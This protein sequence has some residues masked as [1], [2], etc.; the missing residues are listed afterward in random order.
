MRRSGD[1]MFWTCPALLQGRGIHGY[2]TIHGQLSSHRLLHILELDRQLRRPLP[3]RQR[4]SGSEYHVAVR[5]C[6]FAQKP[7]H[8][9]LPNDRPHQFK[10]NGTYRTPW[11][12]LISGN[13][14]AQ[15]GAPFSQ[16]IPHPV[17]GDNEG[18][19][20]PR[21]TAIVPAIAASQPGFPNVVNSVGKNRTPITSNTDVGLYYPVKVGEGREL[22]LQADWFNV[23]NQQRAVMLD[24]TFLINSGITGVPPVSNPFYGSAVQVQP[25][26]QWRFGARFSF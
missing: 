8:G 20:L 24:Q 18:F 13:W 22:R 14:Y 1:R 7:L 6:Q 17:Y 9:R 19:G 23:F 15:S 21:G 3:Q 25:P 12:V 4:P 5:S 26:S 16:L 10:F 11:K 2:P